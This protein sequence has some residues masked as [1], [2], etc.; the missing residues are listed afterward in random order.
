MKEYILNKNY[1]FS[2]YK[3]VKELVFYRIENEKVRVKIAIPKYKKYILKT[4]K[5]NNHE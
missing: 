5:P 4:L 2:K 3:Y 1:F